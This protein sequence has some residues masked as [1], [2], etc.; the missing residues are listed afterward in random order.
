[1]PEITENYIRL[2]VREEGG[3]QKGSIKTITLDKSKGIKA[4]IGKLKGETS[5][6]IM[7]LLFPK[8]SFDTKTAKKWKEEH[9][10]E[11]YYT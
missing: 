9:N 3:F 1:M 7:T 10:L 8:D 11:N 2:P 6:T 5:T 4:L